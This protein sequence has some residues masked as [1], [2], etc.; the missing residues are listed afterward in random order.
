MIGNEE[1][2]ILAHLRK[3]ARKSLAMISRELGMPIS[4]VFDRVNKLQEE[5]ITKNTTFIDFAKL[6]HGLKINYVIRAKKNKA[7]QLINFL[8][9][10]HKVNSVFKLKND[11]EFVIET[12]FRNM[13][14]FDNFTET[15]DDYKAKNINVINIVE[16]LKKEEFLTN[17]GHVQ[18]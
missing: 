15:L 14:E 13:V 10:N 12:I 9:S 17:A 8:M 3:N 16:E 11:N 5:I 18:G 2:L 1:L 7:K 4:T 6:G